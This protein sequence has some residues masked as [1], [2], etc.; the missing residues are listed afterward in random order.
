MLG[1][2][3][4]R[5]QLEL[6]SVLLFNSTAHSGIGT[7]HVNDSHAM[8]TRLVMLS[9]LRGPAVCSSFAYMMLDPTFTK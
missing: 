3:F 1:N 8:P 6:F 4:Y 5:W 7:S 2:S 9:H